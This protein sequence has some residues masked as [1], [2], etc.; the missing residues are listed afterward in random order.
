MC[1]YVAQLLMFPP[2][3]FPPVLSISL[4]LLQEGLGLAL[5]PLYNAGI[6]LRSLQ[7]AVHSVR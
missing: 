7:L 6:L 3:F 2:L 5:I 1:S 4:C